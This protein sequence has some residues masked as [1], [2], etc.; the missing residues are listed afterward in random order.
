MKKRIFTLLSAL[1]ALVGVAWAADLPTAETWYMIQFLNG[2]NVLTAGADGANVT[3]QVPTGKASQWWKLSGSNSSGYTLVSKSGL[4]LTNTTGAQGG[5]FQA[6]S[7]PSANTLYTLLTTTNT[8]YSGAWVIAPKSNNSVFMNQWG[9]AATGA[10]LGLWNNRADANQP[11]Q[12]I[13]EEEWASVGQP[14][15]L[16]PYPQSVTRGDGSIGLAELSSIYAANADAFKAAEGFAADVARVCGLT[17]SVDSTGGEGISLIEDASQPLDGYTLS[18]DSMGVSITASSYGGYFYALQTLRQLLPTAIYGDKAVADAASWTLPYVTITDYP[19]ME[20]RGFHFDV[21]RHFFT[22]D[23]VKKLLRTAATYKFNRFHWHLTDDQGWRIEIPEYPKLTEIG[24][25]RKQSLTLGSFYDD[26]K[27]G[28]DCYYTLAELAEMVEYAK[29][30]NIEIMPEI[31]MPGHMVAAVASY[32]ELSCDPTKTYEVRV[33]SG[34]SQDVLNIGKDET[35]DFLKCVL[36][37]VAETF[38]FHIIHLGG[39]EC[40]TTQW[41]SNADCLKRVEDEGLSGVNGLQAW[42]VQTLGAWLRDNYGKDVAV[43]DELLQY[44]PDGY[45]LKPYIVAW[46]EDEGKRINGTPVYALANYAAKLG[47]KSIHSPY[48]TLYLDFQQSDGS[49]RKIDEDYSGGWGVNTVPEIYNYNVLKGMESGNESFMMGAQGNLWTET[50]S[51]IE[52]AEYQYYPRLLALAE[53]N[54]LAT[55][56]KPGWLNFYQRLQTNVKALDAQDVNYAKH[57]IEEPDLTALESAQAEAQALLE[58]TNPTAVGHPGTAAVSA[59]E[60]ALADATEAESLLAAIAAFKASPLNM[61][62]TGEVYRIKSASTLTDQRYDGSSVYQKSD[63]LAI[64]YTPQAE[65]EELWQFILQDDSTY[66]LQHAFSGKQL[67]MT[68]GTTTATLTDAGTP[69]EIIAAT[70]NGSYTYRPGAI[71]IKAK[72][73]GTD[74]RALTAQNSG[75]LLSGTNTGICTPGTWRIELV[76]NYSFFLGELIE[77]CSNIVFD[78]KPGEMG[79]P[80]QEALDFLEEKIINPGLE[81]VTDSG[82]VSKATYEAFVELYYQYLAMPRTSA[83]DA[84]VE[85]HYYRIRNAYFTSYVARLDVSSKIVKPSTTTSDDAALWCVKKQADGTV[86]LYNKADGTYPAAVQS[87]AADQAVR[88]NIAGTYGWTLAQLTTDQSQTGLAILDKTGTYSWYTNPSSF[89]NIIFKPK[90]WGASIWTFEDTGT[91]VPTSISS[92]TT[93]ASGTS[94]AYDLQGRRVKSDARGVVIEHGRKVVK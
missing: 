20:W 92:V 53:T 89:A 8:T 82:E 3:V 4:T 87:S 47:F 63:Q 39:D 13:S 25:V 56:K 48:N 46:N 30:L 6:A 86:L 84:I 50:C 88:V 80:S 10:Q 19:Q 43:W 59:L 67:T 71:A 76:S 58:A 66:I 5:M 35:I 27:Y 57:Y 22:L 64:H 24:A 52:Q 34:I 29:A 77:K 33:A 55:D 91:L 16:I 70:P 42:L 72:D 69:V 49:L 68:S 1:C 45:D 93:S 73:A 75:I 2:E 79:E 51:S 38:P 18:I 14:L 74:V 81:A 78:A 15:A 54:W 60:A 26:T 94:A 12:F 9:G 65:P 17:L 31:D 44:W 62:A 90:D 37:H 11:L 28:E 40:P 36:G 21:S 32:P 41:S 85:G 61:P 83:I 23:E 7:A